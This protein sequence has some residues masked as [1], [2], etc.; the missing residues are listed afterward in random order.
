MLEG[1]LTELDSTYGNIEVHNALFEA[2]QRAVKFIDR[3]AVVPVLT[4]E[5]KINFF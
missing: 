5:L 4:N 1:L 3:M 2:S